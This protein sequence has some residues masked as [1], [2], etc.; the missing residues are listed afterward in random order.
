M[1]QPVPIAAPSALVIVPG[2]TEALARGVEQDHGSGE[3]GLSARAPRGDEL[4][5]LPLSSR[6]A[7]RAGTQVA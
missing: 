6:Y 7:Y 5:A 4:K 3:L 1:C 2:P